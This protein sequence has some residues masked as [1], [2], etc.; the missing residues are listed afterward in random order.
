MFL[1]LSPYLTCVSFSTVRAMGREWSPVGGLRVSLELK[2]L[3]IF[4]PMRLGLCE[5][6]GLRDL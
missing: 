4:S 3:S 1:E 2:D 6:L 5:L